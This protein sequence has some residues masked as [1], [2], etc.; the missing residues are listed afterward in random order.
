MV[1][2]VADIEGISE[3]W[4]YCA[5]A[6]STALGNIDYLQITLFDSIEK[7]DLKGFV[8]L[9]GWLAH[10]KTLMPA[11]EILVLY[12]NCLLPVDFRMYRDDIVKYFNVKESKHYGY[13]AKLPLYKDHIG[14]DDFQFW[15][16]HKESKTCEIYVPKH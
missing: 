2:R 12:Q 15:L 3:S 7:K 13:D 11:D 16:I 5:F 8:N 9:K 6:D 1:V 4:R 14:K 10:S